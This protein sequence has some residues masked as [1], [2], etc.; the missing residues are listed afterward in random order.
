MRYEKCEKLLQLAL[1]MQAAR[2]GLSLQDIEERCGVGR[3]TAQ[4]MRDAILRLFPQAD[5]V[6]SDERIKRWRI[7]AGVLDRLVGVGTDDLA[8]LEFAINLLRRENLPD[9]A[10]SLEGLSAKLKALMKPDVALR[11]EPDLEALLES[12]GL[13]M[14]AGPRP[15]IRL[16]VQEE[17]RYAIKACRRVYIHHRNRV[18]RR[19]GRRIVCPYGFLHG[20]RHYLVADNSQ[21]RGH[22]YRLFSLPNIE[23]VEVTEDVFERD[24]TFSLQEF[25]ERSFGVFQEEPFKAVWRFLP[26]AADNA[27]EFLFHP[28]QVLEDQPDGS[29]IVR[30]RAG[31]ALE[32]C[33]HLYMWGDQVEVI[34]PKELVKMCH[35]NR[36]D[37]PGMP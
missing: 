29:L 10:A 2:T 7:P 34:E 25:A 27:R 33:W 30:F 31:G 5:E 12:E 28:K 11:V 35:R 3:R 16:I 15:R 9:R 19:L 17:L 32:M 36:S 23:R 6:S 22:D 13:A 26:D 37:W 24:E 8:D 1:E 21:G 4:R 14:R 20:H 18:T